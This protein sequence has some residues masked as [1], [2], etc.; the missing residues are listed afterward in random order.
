MFLLA[1]AFVKL[2]AQRYFDKLFYLSV[3]SSLPF[4]GYL[5]A[6]GSEFG[7][8]EVF[9][10][11]LWIMTLLFFSIWNFYALGLVAGYQTATELYSDYR[12]SATQS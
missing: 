10:M 3:A 9:S 7:S 12:R 4:L 11:P 8:A 5:G 2:E 1:Y 6:Y